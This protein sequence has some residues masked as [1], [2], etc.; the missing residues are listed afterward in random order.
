M[1]ICVVLALIP[2]GIHILRHIKIKLTI[3]TKRFNLEL[4]IKF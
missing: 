3:K 1:S 2:L 4:N